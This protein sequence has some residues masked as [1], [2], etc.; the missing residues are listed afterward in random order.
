MFGGGGGGGGAIGYLTTKLG[1]G[2]IM[3]KTQEMPPTLGEFW[4]ALGPP[5]T[6]RLHTTS[7]EK[8]I[9]TIENKQLMM[10][11]GESKMQH[12]FFNKGSHE[13]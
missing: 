1:G 10:K 9:K 6:Q 12:L 11:V 4:L 3:G 2:A 7:A 8:T 13:A 5:S